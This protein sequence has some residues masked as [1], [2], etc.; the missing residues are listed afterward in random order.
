MRIPVIAMLM[1]C[2]SITFG[3]QKVHSIRRAP[4][5]NV[6]I[7]QQII[8]SN[9]NLNG[10]V[11]TLKQEPISINYTTRAMPKFIK[12]FLQQYSTD[13][14]TIADTGQNWNCCC[15]HDD[16]RPNRKLIAQGSNRHLYFISYLT[17]GEGETQHLVLIKY[18]GNTITDFWEG[19]LWGDLK[20]RD[21]IINSLKANK[22]SHFVL[23]DVKKLSI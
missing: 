15:D 20:T 5:G 4:D 2:T 17:G 3:Q 23:S 13:N 11:Q 1:M 10:F 18:Q 6:Y 8:L 9:A 21:G 19:M 12:T 22:P 16:K 14:F 7:D